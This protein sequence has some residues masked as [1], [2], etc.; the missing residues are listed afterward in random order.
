MQ[1]AAKIEPRD[2]WIRDAVAI[3]DYQVGPIEIPRNMNDVWSIRLGG[4]YAVWNDRMLVSAGANYETSSFDDAHLTP[5]TLDSD[6]LVLGL[7]LSV[8]VKS[9]LWLDVSYAHVFIR[10][11][12][13]RNSQV[14]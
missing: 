12:E 4:S 14:P 2:V 1:T 7:G 9:G 10:D 13:V 8:E 3:G 11:R 6:K 5:L